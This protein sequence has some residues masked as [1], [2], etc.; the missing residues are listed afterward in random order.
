MSPRHPLRR[1]VT[2]RELYAPKPGQESPTCSAACREAREVAGPLVGKRVRITL[3][4]PRTGANR[5]GTIIRAPL[6]GG[7]PLLTVEVDRVGWPAGFDPDYTRG[8]GGQGG[9]FVELRLDE[10]ALQ[11]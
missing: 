9:W 4:D 5:L 11:L 2:C 7:R 3:D 6:V 8:R 10:V 1:C